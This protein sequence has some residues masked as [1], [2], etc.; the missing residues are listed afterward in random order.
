[1]PTYDQYR[2]PEPPI[3][4]ETWA[5][6]MYGAGVE[7]IGRNSEPERMPVTEPGPDQL[8]V[9]V[10]AVGMC[11]SDVKLI[12]QGGEHPKLYHRNLAVEPTRLGHEVALTVVKV[13]ENLRQ[14]YHPGQRL[15]LQPDI[16]IQGKSTAYGYT[17]PG[18]L[19]QFHLIGPEVLEADHQTYVLPLPGDLGYAETAL[20]EPWACVEAAYTQRRRLSPKNGGSMWIVGY[21]GDTTTYQFSAGLEAPAMIVATDAPPAVLDLLRQEAGKREVD[22]IIRNGLAPADYPALKT[23][24]TA[25]AGFDDIIL[26]DPRSAAG[27]S[28][29]AKLIARRG[30]FNMVGQTPL[31]GDVPVDVGRVHYDYTA[32]VGN[33]GPDIAASYGEAR[34]RCD[35]RPGGTAL[36]VG[37]GGPM[38]QMHVQRAIELEN[39][40]TVIIATDVSAMRLAALA[41][42]FGGLAEARHKQLLT[43]NP[44]GAQES[45]R[46]MVMRVTEGHG[47]DDVIVSAPVAAV[48]AEAATTMAPDGMLVFF[49]GVPNGTLAPLNLSAVYLR[50]AQYTGTSGS[51]LADQETVIQKTL[52]GQL[53]PNRSVAAVG[54]LEAA[55]DGIRAM[56][57]GRY[58]GKVVIFPQL[59]GLPLTGVTEL[60]QTLPD[61]A[62]RLAMG[63]VWTAAAEQA[64]IERFWQP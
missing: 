46:E 15:A 39:G 26:L 18:G 37:A 41:D 44:T 23:E 59:Q 28:E 63:D 1:M 8:L 61:V 58:P 35:L 31:D 32:Y 5:W 22:L 6:N 43:F 40:P 64:L 16:Y 27:V 14:Q 7:N 20:T 52:A 45:L 11:F 42:R 21:P 62:E 54:G 9:R 3:P 47:A 57:E 51:A 19:T 48:M 29:A 50:N 12:T 30:T 34:N 55:L 38:G 53:S 4:A 49:A 2:S 60:K 17:I 33:R 24:L 25:G 13:G 56:M 10:D 36:F